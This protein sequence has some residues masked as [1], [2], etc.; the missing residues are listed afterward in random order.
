[1]AGQGNITGNLP[2]FPSSDA[3][4]ALVFCFVRLYTTL[5]CEGRIRN[6]NGNKISSTSFF[7]RE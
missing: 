6:T 4:F 7:M 2:Q 1:M 3:P 5:A